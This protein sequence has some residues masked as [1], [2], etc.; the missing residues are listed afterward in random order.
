MLQNS[1]LDAEEIEREKNVVIEEIKRHEDTPDE[2][3][4]DI[5]LETLWPGHPLGRSIIGRPEVIAALTRDDIAEYLRRHYLPQRMVVAAAGNVGGDRIVD[6]VQRYLGGMA[7]SPEPRLP[8]AP[9]VH[10]GTIE[11]SRSTEQVHFCVGTRG[12]TQ[13]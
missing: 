11:V 8:T 4:H 2:L 12:Y 5:F 9:S 6:C 3:I 10:A 13:N 1:L 7:G